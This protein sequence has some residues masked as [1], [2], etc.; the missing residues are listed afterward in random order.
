MALATAT[1]KPERRRHPLALAAPSRIGRLIVILNLMGLAVLVGGALLLN[2][3]RQGLVDARLDSLRD[4]GQLIAN[5]IDKVATEGDPEPQL[6]ADAA[7]DVLQSLP[8]P[9]S[10]RVR[11]FDAEGNLIAD[12]YV[13][14]DRVEATPLPPALKPGDKPFTLP[15]FGQPPKSAAAAAA[16]LAHEVSRALEGDSVSG[17]RQAEGGRVVSVSIPIEHVRAVVGVLTIEAGDVDRIIAAERMALL[18]FIVI[19][20]AV[21]LISSF[22]LSQL[23]AQPVRR[24]ANA[25]DSVRLSRARAI[26]LPDIA[27]RK[28]ELGELAIS[29]E[30]M[31][32]TLSDRMEAIERFAADVAHEIRNPLT[33]IRSAV[34]TLELVSDPTARERLLRILKQDV[35]RLDR[36]ITDISNASRLD[37][38]LAR[39]SPRPMPLGRVLHDIVGLYGETRREGEPSVRLIGDDVA[40]T[41]A[42]REAPLG[43]VFRNLIDNARSFS[44]PGGE[45]RVTLARDR[46]QA[47]VTVDD[48]GPGM[49]PDNLETVFE[50]FY[51]SR[52]PG[53]A[54]G[55]NSGL[56]LSIARQIVE[57]HGGT[58][59][60]ENRADDTGKVVGARFIVTL[61]ATGAAA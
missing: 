31:T 18:P 11:L 33:S 4:E 9:R 28:D 2:E 36:L 22:A 41:V 45:V 3:L 35:S 32:H 16:A 46:G 60:A 48:D 8:V 47:S 6:E 34:E 1:A 52:P 30:D 39:D 10:E 24:L 51:T 19:A 23:I 50:R 53:A 59:R 40:A 37:A 26:A 42:A 21:N 55:G 44:P 12:S 54:F 25:A 43:Q 57:A 15:G 29:L 14:S 49:P 38:E 27:E 5:V 13:A 56:G 20:V 58:I 7:S 17:M 61:P